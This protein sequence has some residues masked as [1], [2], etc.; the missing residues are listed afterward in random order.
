MAVFSDNLPQDLLSKSH[1]SNINSDVV[2]EVCYEYQ[3]TFIM[4]TR[5]FQSL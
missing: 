3:D 4:L 2:E 5:K 1:F